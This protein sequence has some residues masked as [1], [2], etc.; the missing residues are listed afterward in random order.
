[1]WPHWPPFSNRLS[2]NDPLFIFHILLSPNDPIFKMLSHLMN[3]LFF[4]NIYRWKWRHALTE[5]RP[6]SPINDHLV[7]C[8][9]YLFGRRDLCSCWIKFC[10][11][12][13]TLTTEWPLFFYKLKSSL[14][15]FL[16]FYSPHQMTPYFCPHWKTPFFLYLVCH[17]KTPTLGVVSAH[18]RHFHMWVPPGP[19]S[20]VAS[21]NVYQ[22]WISY[23][24]RMN[25]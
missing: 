18:P 19:R 11:K 22:W 14:K 20:R 6:F 12:I 15:D 1:M 4:R 8:T 9:Q 24:F 7:I 17:R 13:E 23:Q 16:L 21:P 2:L 3:P 10:T 25:M 5:W